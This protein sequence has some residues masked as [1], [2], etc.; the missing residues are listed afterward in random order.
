MY[1]HLS[2]LFSLPIYFYFYCI[3]FLFLFIL[4]I[5]LWIILRKYCKE[6]SMCLKLISRQNQGS[7]WSSATWTENVIRNHCNEHNCSGISNI[8][9][10][11]RY[12]SPL[13]VDWIE[14]HVILHLGWSSAKCLSG[15][16]FALLSINILL[17]AFEIH[18]HQIRY[19]AI[20]IPNSTALWSRVLRKKLRS[21][22]LAKMRTSHKNFTFITVFA[23]SRC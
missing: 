12:I 22:H 6:W 9:T 15:V 3:V 7:F 16:T 19:Y 10:Y 20:V 18:E 13:F 23:R 2:F 17:S 5:F 1:F 8:Y 4:C 14:L 21:T 11:S